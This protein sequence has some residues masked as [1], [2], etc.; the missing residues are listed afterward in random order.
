MGG[1][2]GGGDE[3]KEKSKKEKEHPS[4]KKTKKVENQDQRTVLS[5]DES[6]NPLRRGEGGGQRDA[7]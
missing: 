5:R 1:G 6:W 4:Q 2:W 3:E 7:L